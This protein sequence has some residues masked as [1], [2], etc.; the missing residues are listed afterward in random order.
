MS[1]FAEAPYPFGLRPRLAHSLLFDSEEARAGEGCGLRARAL[2]AP[3]SGF[4]G[5]NFAPSEPAPRAVPDWPIPLSS[6]IALGGAMGGSL[7]SRLPLFLISSQIFPGSRSW[8]EPPGRGDAPNVLIGPGFRHDCASVHPF[9]S[10]FRGETA[11][12]SRRAARFAQARL[13]AEAAPRS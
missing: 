12:L 4:P 9:P 10:S 7:I 3:P 5:P 6:S 8:E 13:G 11:L 2:P 1:A